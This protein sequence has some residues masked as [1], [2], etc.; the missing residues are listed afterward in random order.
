MVT[1]LPSYGNG[2]RTQ[3]DFLLYCLTPIVLGTVG[4]TLFWPLNVVPLPLGFIVGVSVVAGVATWVIFG[5]IA[6]KR[7]MEAAHVGRRRGNRAN[8]RLGVVVA[9]H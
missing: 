7:Q 9:D 3:S 5:L 8:R 6:G 1:D 2:R 4:L